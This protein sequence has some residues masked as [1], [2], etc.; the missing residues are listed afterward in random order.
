MVCTSDDR[1]SAASV[2]LSG[3]RNGLFFCTSSVRVLLMA[4]L[5]VL[6]YFR[7]KHACSTVL[8]QKKTP[9]IT[10]LVVDEAENM[11]Q[12]RVRVYTK[13]YSFYDTHDNKN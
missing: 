10:S 4:M 1:L 11:S 9:P 5:H 13:S 12:M 3:G 8:R 6:P 7:L 2:L